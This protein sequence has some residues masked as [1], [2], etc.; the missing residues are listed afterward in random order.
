VITVC[1]A[2]VRTPAQ[3]HLAREEV[4]LESSLNDDHLLPSVRG[5]LLAKLGRVDEART[6]FERASCSSSASDVSRRFKATRAPVRKAA[7]L[8]AGGRHRRRSAGETGR[9][10]DGSPHGEF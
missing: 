5:D 9:R 7:S 8:A 4:T 1:N 2:R 10:P 6:E 3:T